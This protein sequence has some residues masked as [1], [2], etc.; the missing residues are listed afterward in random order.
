MLQAQTK[1][2]IPANQILD[3]ETPVV[4]AL[5]DSVEITIANKQPKD[6][7]SPAKSRKQ[8]EQQTPKE[9]SLQHQSQFKDTAKEQPPVVT[10]K[11]SVVPQT[12]VVTKDNKDV[13]NLNQKEEGRRN[14]RKEKGG[15]AIEQKVPPSVTISHDVQ[16][17]AG[18][19]VSTLQSSS[20]TVNQEVPVVS[21]KLKFSTIILR[22]L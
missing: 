3:K 21:G 8:R 13:T 22:W 20:A 5:T 2:F 4:S 17:G 16:E 10:V 9:T 6:R 7:E 14:Q 11:D 15:G 19:P 12:P 1:E 18:S